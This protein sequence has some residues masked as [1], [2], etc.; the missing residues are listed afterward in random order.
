ML[1][2]A[3]CH[4]RTSRLR[5]Q[6]ALVTFFNMANESR[7]GA[8]RKSSQV[9]PGVHAGIYFAETSA[10]EKVRRAA[11]LEEVS[12][13]EFIVDAALKQAERVVKRKRAA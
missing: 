9:R 5:S 2:L 13:N 7:R 10:K 8:P 11:D 4:P 12:F 3:K 1:A 6:A